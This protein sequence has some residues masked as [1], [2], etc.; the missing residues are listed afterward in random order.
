MKTFAQ[1]AVRL[2]GKLTLLTWIWL[3]TGLIG[4]VLANRFGSGVSL[5][6]LIPY[7]LVGGTLLIVTLI[8][9]NNLKCP[10]CGK[11]ILRHAEEA[12]YDKRTNF[13]CPA[14]GHEFCAETRERTTEIKD[15][16]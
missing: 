4:G 13:Y 5:L 16:T 12:V 9:E 3:A 8:A 14:C 2:A 15:G 6:W 10:G 11:K 7:L 1:S